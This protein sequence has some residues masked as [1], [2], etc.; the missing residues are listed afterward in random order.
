MPHEGKILMSGSSEQPVEVGQCVCVPL[1]RRMASPTQS[2]NLLFSRCFLSKCVFSIIYLL[3]NRVLSGRWYTS[4]EGA[5]C[6][7]LA[8]CEIL[9]GAKCRSFSY[10]AG[11][12]H[13]SLFYR[14]WWEFI[15]NFLLQLL[16][17]KNF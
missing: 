5:R 11:L 16:A 1:D 4:S 10:K 12:K 13:L 15:F 2:R 14:Q 9:P 7:E 17:V 8:L 6:P 3:D